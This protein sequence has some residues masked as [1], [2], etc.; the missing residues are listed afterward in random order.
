MMH[1]YVYMHI[2]IYIVIKGLM[3][4]SLWN[5]LQALRSIRMASRHVFFKGRLRG[6][7]SVLLC[8]SVEPCR[9]TYFWWLFLSFLQT[10]LTQ[11]ALSLP[12]TH[13]APLAAELAPAPALETSTVA[14]P[15]VDSAFGSAACSSGDQRVTEGQIVG[16]LDRWPKKEHDTYDIHNHAW[17]CIIMHNHAQ[18]CIS[19]HNEVDHALN[20]LLSFPHSCSFM[21][22]L[23]WLHDSP[24]DIRTL[25]NTSGAG[26]WVPLSHFHLGTVN[27]E[28]CGRCRRQCCWCR[29]HWQW[30]S[31]KFCFIN[32]AAC[33]GSK[34]LAEQIMS[35][36][37][38][39][40][41]TP[42]N[43]VRHL[44]TMSACLWARVLLTW[45]F[46]IL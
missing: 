9:A 38:G 4:M 42:S 2:Y 19:M 8:F 1:L 21:L 12:E 40:M 25:Q 29:C 27:A 16:R 17:S 28:F 3:S 35:D 43:I 11:G 6:N 45:H 15:D 46:D 33:R 22:M 14:E 39:H 18:A 26:F 37:V 7:A 31:G 23:K 30:G 20:G 34:C 5:V 44:Q 32:G 10:C 36:M 13:S 41:R 24:E